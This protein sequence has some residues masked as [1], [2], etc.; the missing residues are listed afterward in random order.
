VD[1][2]LAHIQNRDR[3]IQGLLSSSV[4]VVEEEADFK[5]FYVQSAENLLAH[6]QNRERKIQGLLS[7]SSSVEAVKDVDFSMVPAAIEEDPFDEEGNLKGVIA[8]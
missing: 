7:S 2:L 6:I 4:E 3:E 5:S 8:L 1:S